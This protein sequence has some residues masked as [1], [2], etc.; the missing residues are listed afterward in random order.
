MPPPVERTCANGRPPTVRAQSAIHAAHQP[1]SHASADAK[2]GE[3]G[4]RTAA[5]KANAS[6]EKRVRIPREQDE[7][8]EQEEVPAVALPCR[9]PRERAE[10][11]D[12][13]R[14]QH[15][16]LRPDREDVRT[17]S[18]QRRELAEPTGD[19]E[20]PRNLECSD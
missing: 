1:A 16:R 10:R 4:S 12:D 18:R 15:R 11:A 9:E 20:R 2:A 13:A 8:G 3:N 14:A 7:R 5:S 17:D 6:S 19:A